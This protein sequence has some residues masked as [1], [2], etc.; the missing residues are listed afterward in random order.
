MMKPTLYELPSLPYSP[1]A[2]DGFLTA[3]MLELHH[4]KHHADDV[5]KLNATLAAIAGARSENR[6]AEL[7]ALHRRL[8]FHGSSHV[9]H[10][11]YWTSMSPAGGGKPVGELARAV[12]RDFGGMA[13]LRRQFLSVC[14]GVE[15]EGWGILAYEPIG[16]RLIV[17]SVEGHHGAGFQGAAP[18]MVCDVWEHAYYLGYRNRRAQ[19]LQGFFEVIDWQSAN[20]RF[21]RV[22]RPVQAAF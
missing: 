5:S 2:L 9:L 8:A 21:E 16:D 6:T 3:E 13:G 10:S 18:L 15:R 19:Y 7:P 14:E 4:D 17:T 22:C 20:L 12:E 1:D 11:L